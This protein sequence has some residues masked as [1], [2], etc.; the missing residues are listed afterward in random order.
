MYKKTNR[1]LIFALLLSVVAGLVCDYFY[2]S[3]PK[4]AVDIAAFQ[5][6]LSA[7]ETKAATT[8]NELK[9][10]IIH[11]SID[12]LIHY[13]FA[14]NNIS[15]YV[16]E[17]GELAFWS[18]NNLDISRIAL[19]DSTDWHYMP[20]P[21]AHCVS[22]ILTYESTTILALI[23]IKNNYP[24]ENNELINNFSRGFNI[25]QQ[26]QIVKGKSTDKLAVFCTHGNYLFSFEQ[27]KTAIYNE[28][29]ALA[30]LIAYLL[31]FLLLFAL[32]CRF[33]YLINKKAISAPYFLIVLFIV[34]AFVGLCLY[35]NFPAL[36]FWSKVFTPLQYAS[37][38]MLASIS[39]LTI[40]T[41]Y[42]FSSIYLF[43]FRV[44]T[45]IYKSITSRVILQ[46]ILVLY[47]IFIYD[48]LC[49]LINHSSIQLS[50][51]RINDFSFISLWIH[52]L[53]LLWGIG[54]ALLFF[55]AH[56]LH[57]STQFKKAISIDLILLAITCIMCIIFWPSDLKRIGIPFVALWTVFY[58][59]LFFPKYKNIYVLIACWTFVFTGFLV[60]NSIII[61]QNKK[62]GKY[63][64]LA[65]NI[66]IN[67]NTEN[68]K[69]ADILLEELDVQIT[70][71]TKIARLL[72]NTDSLSLA[73]DYLNKT[74]LRGFWNKYEMR[75]NA[76]KKHSELYNEYDKFINN[77]GTR[78][79]R[80]HFYSVPANDNNM[81][82]IGEFDA[83]TANTD[84]TVFFMEF[85]PR[86]N[87]KSY[88]FPNLLIASSPDIQTQLN[89]AVAK[90][91]HQ[92]LVY[93]SGKIEFPANTGWIPARNKEFF[94]VVYKN[95]V[96]YIY[97]PNNDSFIVITEQQL[98]DPEA[99][100]LYFAYT[101]LSY[102]AL[103]CLFAW[104]FLLII[105]KKDFRLGLTAKFQYAFITLLVLSFILIFYVSVN[106]IQNKY[107]EEQIANLESK[108]S[109][110]QKALQDI[111]YWNQDLNGLN[112]QNL[113]F[114]LQ[115]LSYIYHTDIHVYDNR[116]VLVGSSQPIIFNKNLISNRI[117]PTPFFKLN[118]N[119]N[120]YEH[121]GKLNYLTGYTDFY[122]GDYLQIGYI[123]IPQF[124]S[125]NEIRDEIE[126][127]LA[128]IIHIYLI[129]IV[130]AILLSLFIGKQLSAPLNMLE[131]KLKEMRLGRR[132]EKIDYGL[133]DEIGQLVVQ[134]NRT[135][136]ELEQSAKLL[137]Q[138]ERETAW[139]SMAR[140]VA[141]EINNPLTPMK[142]TIQQLQRTKK[143]NDERFDDYFAKST[144]ML[145][146]QIDNLSRIAGTFS[147]FA[148]M[149]EANF[150]RVD[151][152]AKI[153]SVVQLFA[154]NYEHV[155][156]E[157][158]GSENGVFV[159][160][161]P[162]QLVQVF[163]NLLKNAIQAIPSERDGDIQTRLIQTDTNI[164]IEVT[165]NGMGI[166]HEAHD[167]LFVPNFTTKTTGMGL[168]LA[169]AKNIIELS[170]GTISFTS[171]INLGTTFTV[172]LPKAD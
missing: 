60:W 84:S 28:T 110:I 113:N 71:D 61:D 8:M 62:T 165:D 57:K 15:Y 39:H 134:Y 131:N 56:S 17:K 41:G 10:I 22:R 151:I 5:K 76:T 98:H 11:S 30:G 1:I 142:L 83:R 14:K 40:A 136:D 91:E 45:E 139:K 171:K 50:I 31:A 88:S 148:R 169:I 33:P 27:P 49:G 167:K 77:S 89:L 168:G 122:N 106:F 59:P 25:D 51:L 124:F 166:A 23:N 97:A 95:R 126:S 159:Y 162:E 158:Q 143:L 103:C 29:W 119:I 137:A 156:I 112:T 43:H 100:L 21:N 69:M 155:N 26:V 82:Y 66:S 121:I 73:N 127:F 65:Q 160:A 157:Y 111:Y 117:S 20:L 78:I 116:G 54:L 3:S 55:K 48:L 46:I 74:Y 32:Y 9:S 129:I 63:K 92:K 6:Q 170:N 107:K 172:T 120:Q 52:F 154:N 87:F 24:Y 4:N 161:D 133:N 109:Y 72:K 7:K 108:K 123:A 34:G 140:Q 86:S 94:S 135:V 90:Y 18:D 19:P 164:L 2:N 81:S 146:E 147:N 145:I 96:H 36:L 37:N 80:T 58:I 125:Q 150:E 35:H 79:K 101:F 144:V 75:L 118:A 47:F 67:G 53:I 138:S 102:F 64:I 70:S 13:P 105:R 93:S 99:Y 104:L 85:Y 163:N 115:D 153:R 42:I 68:D 152:A 12:S 38:P 114:D 130:L 132:N 141:H 128:V 44:K 149:P 16:F